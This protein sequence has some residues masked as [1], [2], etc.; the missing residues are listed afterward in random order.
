MRILCV[1]VICAMLLMS[2][3]C[4][5]QED[6]TVQELERIKMSMKDAEAKSR[7]VTALSMRQNNVVDPKPVLIMAGVGGDKEETFLHMATYDENVDVIGLGVCE[8]WNTVDGRRDSLVEEYPVFAAHSLDGVLSYSKVPVELRDSGQ[9]K[10]E[11][12]WRIYAEERGS[13][14][15][16][17][18]DSASNGK[19]PPIYVS[20]P[21]PNDTDVFVYVYDRSGHKSDSVRLLNVIRE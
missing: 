7:I 9:R 10:D 21:E 16:S 14:E 12:L 6:G 5:K 8:E 13:K 4:A 19:I 17:L 18:R 3:G 15:N 2:C 1:I 11:E 20:I